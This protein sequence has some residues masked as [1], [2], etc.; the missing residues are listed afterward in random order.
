MPTEV[1]KTL[2]DFLVPE[3]QTV[4]S[5]PVGP[6]VESGSSGRATSAWTTDSALQY[7]ANQIFKTQISKII[8]SRSWSNLKITICTIILSERLDMSWRDNLVVKSICCSSRG[9]TSGVCLTPASGN[10]YS[11]LLRLQ[12]TQAHHINKNKINLK[13]TT[14]K[15][16][17]ASEQIKYRWENKLITVEDN[18]LKLCCKWRTSLYLIAT[19]SLET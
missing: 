6:G 9:R 15:M 4:V 7:H 3:I 19:R 10:L 18:V 1:R 16:N 14:R 12:Y 5:Y 8:A 17:F 2:S 13:T 11:G